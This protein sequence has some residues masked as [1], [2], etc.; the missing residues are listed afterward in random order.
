MDQ[1]AKAKVAR[2]MASNRKKRLL[3]AQEA[4]KRAN[5]KIKY[6]RSKIVAHAFE[7]TRFKEELERL[8]RRIQSDLGCSR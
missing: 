1:Q 7:K 8:L 3:K 4:L 2:K 5:E 6:F